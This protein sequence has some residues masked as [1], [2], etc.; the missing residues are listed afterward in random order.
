MSFLK[1]LY[2]AYSFKACPHMGVL[3][4]ILGSWFQPS[5][6]LAAA[7]IWEWTGGFKFFLCGYVCVLL[8]LSSHHKEIFYKESTQSILIIINKNHL[9]TTSQL[10]DRLLFRNSF[11]DDTSCSLRSCTSTGT[12][13][14]GHADTLRA[15]GSYKV[16]F[17]ETYVMPLMV[18]ENPLVS[19]TVLLQISE[20]ED[21]TFNKNAVHKTTWH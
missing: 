8:C 6:V 2:A 13:C 11:T 15:P 20:T 10:L 17:F 1:Y 7:G 12:L 21:S 9:T 5:P 18:Q 14:W 16:L 3:D 4:G 19:R